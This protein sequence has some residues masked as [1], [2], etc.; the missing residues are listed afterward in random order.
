MNSVV[1]FPLTCAASRQPPTV[2]VGWLDD[3]NGAFLPRLADLR[4]Q[5]RTSAADL[6]GASF[7][8]AWVV[9]HFLRLGDVGGVGFSRMVRLT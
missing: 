9:S 3:A 6:D 5:W 7:W 8:G 1:G 4:R 2:P